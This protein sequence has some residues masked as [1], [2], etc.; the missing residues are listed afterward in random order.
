MISLKPSD[1]LIEHGIKAI[2]LDPV[3]EK[4]T[5]SYLDKNIEFGLGKTVQDTVITN[6]EAACKEIIPIIDPRVTDTL[7]VFLTSNWEFITTAVKD[8]VFSVAQVIQMHSGTKYV[9]GIL[10]GFSKLNKMINAVN[11]KCINQHEYCNFTARK[12]FPIPLFKTPRDNN[13]KSN[14]DSSN[15][16]TPKCVLCKRQTLTNEYEYANAVIVKL[17]DDDTFSGINELTTI[18][19]DKD[20]IDIRMGE[21]VTVKGDIHIIEAFGISNQ[22]MSFLF[23][24]S[25]EYQSKEEVSKTAKEIEKEIE[26][27]KKFTAY[28]QRCP[29]VGC[30]HKRSNLIERL[31]SMFAPNVVGHYDK[32][33]AILRSAVNA[34][35]TKNK[36]N[37]NNDPRINTLLIGEPG[38]AK[39]LLG[40]EA[41]DLIPN[42]RY[43]DAP[44]ATG[45]SLTATVDKENDAKMVVVQKTRSF[46]LLGICMI[47][48]L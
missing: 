48:Q 41:T 32:K 8:H 43:C 13:N 23:A 39:S 28:N 6:L 36:I 40:K 10:A 17:M 31:V 27:F 24:K 1:I 34:Q 33:L 14:G 9:S 30:L 22:P 19:F 15:S 42:A 25:I 5:I 21:I 44:N 4:F 45:V 26:D 2:N 18:L 20:T 12:E 38:L 35:S 11:I 37:V 3:I 46:G 7:K 16:N 47:L 29:V